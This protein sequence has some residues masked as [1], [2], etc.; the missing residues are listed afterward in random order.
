MVIS[1]RDGISPMRPLGASL[2]ARDGRDGGAIDDARGWARLWTAPPSEGFAFLGSG[3]GEVPGEW[4]A[5]FRFAFV[6]EGSSMIGVKAAFLSMALPGDQGSAGKRKMD[7]MVWRGRWR[8]SSEPVVSA[9][10]AW[11]RKDGEV[12]DAERDCE[13]R[14][15]WR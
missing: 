11:G 13:R 7:C 8:L 2:R 10:S 4:A 12:G 3:F 1:A 6:E 5:R 9:K 14:G 15:R